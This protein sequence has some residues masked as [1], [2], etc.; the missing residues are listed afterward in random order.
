MCCNTVMSFSLAVLVNLKLEATYYGGQP[1]K[2]MCVNN[3]SST[4]N[5]YLR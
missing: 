3:D 2:N 4:Q 1:I 5:I